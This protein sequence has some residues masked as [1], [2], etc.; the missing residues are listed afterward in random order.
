MDTFF[1]LFTKIYMD[2]IELYL[3]IE[4]ENIKVNLYIYKKK[5]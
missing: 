2:S 5:K 4:K 3:Y 1:G